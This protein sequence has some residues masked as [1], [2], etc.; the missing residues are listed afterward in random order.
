MKKLTY[1]LSAGVLVAIFAISGC[2]DNGGNEQSAVDVAGGNFSG[3][4][5][6]DG[7]AN[8]VTFDNQDRTANYDD[9]ALSVT[10]NTGQGSGLYTATGT[11]IGSGSSPWP[12]SG[13]WEFE[14]AEPGAKS[15]NIVRDPGSGQELTITVSLTDTDMTLN[16][17]F[18]DSVNK[19]SRTEAVTGPWVF[20]LVKQ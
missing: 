3:T 14:T 4:W 11:I 20:N 19:G 8:S 7:S 15:F 9:F 18:D 1:L 10:Y 12:G 13:S 6:V 5:A 16:F 2:K 17:N